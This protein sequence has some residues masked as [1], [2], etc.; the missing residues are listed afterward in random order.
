MV[1][2]A[3]RRRPRRPTRSPAGFW[4]L[5]KVARARQVARQENPQPIVINE[6]FHFR[7]CVFCARKP[8]RC[9][10]KPQIAAGDGAPSPTSGRP[11]DKR[12]CAGP[13]EETRWTSRL[14]RMSSGGR[15]RLSFGSGTGASEEFSRRALAGGDPLRVSAL[16][17]IFGR[18]STRQRR[19][20]ASS[21]AGID[22]SHFSGVA[23]PRTAVAH[24]P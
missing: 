22:S 20:T 21:P 9:A 4:V 8:A 14:P 16:A 2:S 7:A 19:L 12:T 11:Y 24:A 5:L 13:I 15:A 17:E 3:A 23:W 10:M 1:V 18:R 6:L